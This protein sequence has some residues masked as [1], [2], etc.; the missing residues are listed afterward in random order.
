MTPRRSRCYRSAVLRVARA[1]PALTV[2]QIA[3]RV[4]C[5]ESTARKHLLSLPGSPPQRR[6]MAPAM[7]AEPF[8]WWETWWPHPK[9]SSPTLMRRLASSSEPRLL[10]DAACQNIT[11]P[12]TL[13]MLAQPRSVA[14]AAA[15]AAN[16]NTR[17]AALAH[18]AATADD[19]LV[20]QPAAANPNTPQRI[21]HHLARTAGQKTRSRLAANPRTHRRTLRILAADPAPAVR[22]AAARSPRTAHVPA[23]R[24]GSVAAATLLDGLAFD[25]DPTVRQAAAGNA[26][27]SLRVLQI[28][29]RDTDPRVRRT[30]AERPD[31]TPAILAGPAS[32]R[33]NDSPAA[34]TTVDALAGAA[35]APSDLITRRGAPPTTRQ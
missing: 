26:R 4:G 5:A 2:S 14:V 10:R 22:A 32:H 18:L 20:L 35:S 27:A 30:L 3:T 7:R 34:S 1:Q 29:A 6:V 24:S 33:N 11:A 15:V 16:P 25:P 17:P 19:P 13:S 12:A 8:L 23:P 21:L 31:T 9:P 28:L